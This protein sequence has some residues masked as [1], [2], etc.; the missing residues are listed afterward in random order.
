[1]QGGLFPEG[2][3]GS[4]C[5][6]PQWPLIS[7]AALEGDCQH[8]T[9]RLTLVELPAQLMVR[10]AFDHFSDVFSFLVDWHSPD[11]GTLRWWGHHFDLDGTRLG[12]LAV[13]LFQFGGILNGEQTKRESEAQLG[14]KAHQEMAL[15]T[16]LKAPATAQTLHLFAQQPRFQISDKAP[17]LSPAVKQQSISLHPSFPKGKNLQIKSTSFTRTNKAFISLGHT[18]PLARDTHHPPYKTDGILFTASCNPGSTQNHRHK[19]VSSCFL[20][21]PPTLAEGLNKNMSLGTE[22][23][24][25]TRP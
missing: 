2:L 1:M 21:S 17:R 5:H 13:Q 6:F 4:C 23:Y 3:L 24:L 15:H 7:Q 16:S 9:A 19:N 18:L 20:R 11:D 22:Q 12:D 25:K 8:S 10:A 14:I